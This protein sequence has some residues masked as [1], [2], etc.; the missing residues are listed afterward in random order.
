MGLG[1]LSGEKHPE[2]FCLTLLMR[3]SRSA[4]LLVKGDVGVVGQTEDLVMD[5]LPAVPV[6]MEEADVARLFEQ[7]S[8]LTAPVVDENGMLLGRITVDDVVDVIR[9]EGESVS[10]EHGRPRRGGRSV[11]S[12]ARRVTSPGAVARG[13]SRHRVHRGMSDRT[14]R[15]DDPG[16]CRARCAD[17][18][19]GEHGRHRRQPDPHHRDPCPRSGP[20]QRRELRCAD[21]A[22]AV[23]G[24]NPSLPIES[25]IV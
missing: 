12:G 16:A 8:L 14:L 7:F 2:T 5:D 11:R 10:D 3:K 13:E 17:A 1:V 6:D 24:A 15:S 4:R 25:C 19:G 20:D 22:G 18:G 23:G 9:D 21:V